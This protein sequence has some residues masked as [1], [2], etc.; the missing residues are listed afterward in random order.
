[1]E[2]SNIEDYHE[3]AV[4][5]LP[6]LKERNIRKAPSTLSETKQ[7]KT[8]GVADKGSSAE[9][10]RNTDQEKQWLLIIITNVNAN[11]ASSD[12]DI[13]GTDTLTSTGRQ[14]PSIR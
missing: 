5:C 7:R 3:H 9:K 13:P 11:N 6:T 1:M 10:P 4:R 2:F 14:R 8:C 12:G